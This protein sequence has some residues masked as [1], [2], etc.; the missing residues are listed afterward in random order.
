M[1]YYD[2]PKLS[3]TTLRNLPFYVA[4]SSMNMSRLLFSDRPKHVILCLVL[5]VS[6]GIVLLIIA[7]L[8]M[9]CFER[10][11]EERKKQK[12]TNEIEISLPLLLAT[13]NQPPSTAIVASAT[14]SEAGSSHR[15]AGTQRLQTIRRWSHSVDEGTQTDAGLDEPLVDEHGI[16][17]SEA[18]ELGY[19]VDIMKYYNSNLDTMSAVDG[20]VT[21]KSETVN[22][23]P[24]VVDLNRSRQARLSSA[25]YSSSN[26]SVFAESL[27][28]KGNHVDAA[29]FSSHNRY[30]AT[31]RYNSFGHK[32][33]T[34]GHNHI[35]TNSVHNSTNLENG[36]R[37]LPT[38]SRAGYPSAVSDRVSVRPY[39]TLS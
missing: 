34:L 3:E 7:I 6:V 37:R 1:K 26:N 36:P 29:P 25:T 17:D 11:I 21:D 13:P 4:K 23:R 2:I 9:V 5:S 38:R 39:G 18:R 19:L 33:N 30:R 28:P 20:H 14:P 16:S 10:F 27:T 22:T 31:P 15:E 24:R 32:T 8:L 12:E 35:S